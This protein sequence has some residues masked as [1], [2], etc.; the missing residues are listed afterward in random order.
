M[1]FNIVRRLL[2]EQKHNVQRS[3]LFKFT[4][5][6]IMFSVLDIILYSSIAS[7]KTSI[8]KCIFSPT[9]TVNS[10]VCSTY[11]KMSTSHPIWKYTKCVW[12]AT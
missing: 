3:M 8:L 1:I 7:R 2:Y 9:G 6:L 5:I 12:K 11:G 10:H 4:V